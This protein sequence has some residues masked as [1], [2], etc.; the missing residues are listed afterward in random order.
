MSFQTHSEPPVG[1]ASP[2]AQLRASAHEVF[3]SGRRQLAGLLELATL[4][5]RYSGLM[6]AF[7]LGFGVALAVFLLCG[8]GLL[9]A[10]AVVQ[11]IELGWS[12]AAALAALGLVHALAALVVWG[13]L[14]RC[15][16][17]IGLDGT[18]EVMGLGDVSD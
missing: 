14:R 17:R 4:E 18:R 7:A 6:L 8:W 13:L 16:A 11:L 12:T 15:I 9:V 10:A 3:D 2:A 5:A 1:D